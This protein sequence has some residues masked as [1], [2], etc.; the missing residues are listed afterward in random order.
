M[1]CYL[2]RNLSTEG[3]FTPEFISCIFKFP[4]F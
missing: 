4:A 2:R 1:G 3:D